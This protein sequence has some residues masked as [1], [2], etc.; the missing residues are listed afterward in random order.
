MTTNWPL[1]P[2]TANDLPDRRADSEDRPTPHHLSGDIPCAD[3]GAT[4]NIKWSTDSVFWNRVIRQGD[5]YS[6][7]ILCVLCFTNR[8]ALSGVRP[9][10]WR[11]IPEFHWETEAEYDNR[12][13]RP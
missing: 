13:R 1:T 10:A 7:P 12:T 8:V 6:E 4:D 5:N 2:D 11:L 9:I 3:C